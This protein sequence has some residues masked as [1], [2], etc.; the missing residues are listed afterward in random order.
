M[1]K[2]IKTLKKLITLTVINS[3]QYLYQIPVDQELI[4]LASMFHP[5]QESFPVLWSCYIAKTPAENLKH[6]TYIY[7]IF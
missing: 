1:Y 6:Y 3:V 5:K 4:D 7:N 2:S